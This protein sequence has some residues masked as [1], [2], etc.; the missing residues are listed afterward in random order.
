MTWEGGKQ[1]VML[2]GARFEPVTV[3]TC[4]TWDNNVTRFVYNP[5]KLFR[6][7]ST[8]MPIMLVSGTALAE[9]LVAKRQNPTLVAL[10]ESLSA[11]LDRLENSQERQPP[12]PRCEFGPVHPTSCEQTLLHFWQTPSAFLNLNTGQVLWQLGPSFTFRQ[13]VHL[14]G[15]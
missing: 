13:R 8:K 14:S 11:W 12:S 9:V 6:R 7:F 10:N 2:S 5:S 15:P 1:N 3:K 4:A